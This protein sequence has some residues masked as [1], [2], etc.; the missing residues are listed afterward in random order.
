MPRLF[1]GIE[2]PAEQREEIARLKVPLPGGGRWLEPDDL[3]LTLRFVGDVDNAQATEFADRLETIDVDAFEL[4]LAGLGV[5][6]GNEPRSI[7]AGTEAS[8]PLEA[9][10]RANDR[11]ARAAGLPPEGRQFKPHVTLA[12]LKYA[13]ADEVARVLQRI[14]AFRSKPFIV[15]RFVLFS[16]KPKSGGGP[17][18]IEE[19]FN[20]RGGEYA[21]D[22]DL[23]YGW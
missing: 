16:S 4:R 9:L 19:A 2:I 21:G 6:G 14:G 3:H 1:T 12:R 15:S 7:W 8:A 17:Y 5:F 20:L 11:A 18:V 10:A 13:S 23:D 22:L